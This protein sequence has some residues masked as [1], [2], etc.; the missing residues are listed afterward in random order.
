MDE[1]Q[2]VA[3]LW[4]HEDLVPRL[5]EFEVTRPTEDGFTA[6][7]RQGN[8]PG[9]PGWDEWN[10]PR[11][12]FVHLG[13]DGSGGLFGVWL[14]PDADPPHPVI[15]FGSEGGHGVLASSPERWAQLVAYAPTVEE[16]PTPSSSKPG[17]APDADLAAYRS[18]VEA[19]LGPLPPFTAL[20]NDLDP[21]N[22]VF[23]RWIRQVDAVTDA[24]NAPA[25]RAAAQAEAA[26]QAELA[27]AHARVAVRFQAG[28]LSCPSCG[29]RNVRLLKGLTP[30]AGCGAC[31]R[32]F[33]PNPGPTGS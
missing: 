29:S 6:A 21:L 30:R 11:Y 32:S 33:A 8:R 26:R 2:L 1:K 18:A 19:R 9:D 14:R 5:M 31:G 24:A 10:R 15:F 28:E 7:L 27:S 13:Q 17:T 25:Q 20:V 16:Y 4:Q 23:T 3:W 12:R 22:D